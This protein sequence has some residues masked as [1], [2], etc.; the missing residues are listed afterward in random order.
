[1]F[2]ACFGLAYH[3]LASVSVAFVHNSR[4]YHCQLFLSFIMH[5]AS[6]I[7]HLKYVIFFLRCRLTAFIA[8]STSCNGIATYK[9]IRRVQP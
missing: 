9:N 7:V 2:D 8:T 6:K 1:M 4:V 5:S 3:C